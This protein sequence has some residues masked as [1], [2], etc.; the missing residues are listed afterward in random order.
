MGMGLLKR[1]VLLFD[2][3]VPFQDKQLFK[4]IF[5]YIRDLKLTRR[6]EVVLGGDLADFW[7]ISKFDKI[8]TASIKKEDI[9]YERTEI[10]CFLKDL[11]RA[12]GDARIVYILGNH[13]I[14]LEK[15]L[16]SEAKALS[17]IPEL[18][19]EN[20][21]GL[22]KYNIEVQP[23]EYRPV[24]DFLIKHGESVSKFPARTELVKELLNGA[25]GH[26]H[27]TDRAYMRC[28][29]SIN[30]GRLIWQ[31]FGHL[32]DKDELDFVCKYSEALKW[33][34]SHGLLIADLKNN[35]WDLEVLHCKEKGFYSKHLRKFYKR[36]IV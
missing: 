18:K 25:S 11:R 21:L 3:H 9:E 24:P 32:A 22:G 23:R 2:I 8:T 33:D 29:K 13:E 26:C 20:F 30:G 36:G 28:H 7:T 34:Q 6:D 4:S 17:G 19:F 31:S 1:C 10:K 35:I 27:R 5:K 14:R 12:S 16:S 15:Y